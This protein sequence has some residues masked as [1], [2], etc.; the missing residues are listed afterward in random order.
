MSSPVPRIVLVCIGCDRYVCLKVEVHCGVVHR[1][2]GSCRW[3]AAGVCAGLGQ[4][5][6]KLRRRELASIPASAGSVCQMKKSVDLWDE[7]TGRGAAAVI[8]K[9]TDGLSSRAP[10]SPTLPE[11]G[12]EQNSVLAWA[13]SMCLAFGSTEEI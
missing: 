11:R 13:Q 2:S 4:I 12:T 3:G 6:T 8:R 1:L 5:R 9:R 10:R 7:A